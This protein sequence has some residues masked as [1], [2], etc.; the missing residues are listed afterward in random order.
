M[1]NKVGFIVTAVTA[2]NHPGW[3]SCNCQIAGMEG[4]MQVTSTFSKVHKTL[5]EWHRRQRSRAELDRMGGFEI[6]DFGFSAGD[7]QCEAAKWFWQA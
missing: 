6:G 2:S 5:K 3:N 4:K 7:A 1:V